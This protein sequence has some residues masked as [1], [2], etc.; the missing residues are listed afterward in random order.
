MS[1]EMFMDAHAKL[2]EEYLEQ[3]PDANDQEAYD[4]TADKAWDRARD[5]YADMI[6]AAKQ[7]A[8][9]EGRWPPKPRAA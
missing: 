6:D 5:D 9:D 3:H 4:A 8:K 1:K 7:Q 2:V